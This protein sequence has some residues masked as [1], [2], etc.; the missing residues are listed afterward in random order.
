VIAAFPTESCDYSRLMA[1]RFPTAKTVSVALFAA[2]CAPAAAQVDTPSPEERT[3]KATEL[4]GVE[5]NLKAAEDQRHKMEADVEAIRVDRAR[6]AAAL[7]ETTAKVQETENKRAAANT[8]LEALNA[9]ADALTGSLESRRDVIADVL[10]VLQRIGRH[11]PPAIL[12]KPHDMVEAVRAAMLLGATIPELTAETQALARDLDKLAELR[13]SIAAQRDELARGAEGL[14]RDKARLTELIA[15]R[16]QSLG[17]AESS[18]E[19]ERKRA[20]D[21]AGQAASL[22]DLIAKMESQIGAAKAGAEAALEADRAAAASIA[23]RAA[24]TRGADPAR[25][26]PATPFAE[27]KGQ[28]SLPVAGAV[29]KSFGASDGYGG[30]E[31]GIS[32]ATPPAATVST[33]IDGW[34]VYSGPYRSYGQLLILNA[35]GGYYMVLAGMDR[36]QVSVGQFVLTGEPVAAMGDGSARTA[37][38]A[39][40]GAAQPVL[41]IE[42]RKNETAIDPGPWWSKTNIEKARG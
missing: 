1:I 9:S 12:V 42:L 20:D 27:V 14:A 22:K 30:V 11:P 38:A 40:I 17:A 5:D 21:L 34:V 39:A 31:K 33:P 26:K 29:L 15:A 36:I 25:L 16:Q 24:A 6:L 2:I 7:I 23:S 10:A 18:L 28:L 3:A 35:G 41:Y 32:I 8:R 13:V 19:A 37:A 4:R